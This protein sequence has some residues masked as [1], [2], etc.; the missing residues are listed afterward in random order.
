M[1]HLVNGGGQ[2][3]DHVIHV[4]S[5]LIYRKGF[6]TCPSESNTLKSITSNIRP[7]ACLTS[8]A[9][10]WN[11]APRSWH[12]THQPR[13]YTL[14]YHSRSWTLHS[15]MGNL[16]I[17]VG[18]EKGCLELMALIGYGQREISCSRKPSRNGP[19]Q[20]GRK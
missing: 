18:K 12:V 7:H 3:S 20:F 11:C 16:H 10:I 5:R 9:H 14:G 2:R 13:A 17:Q 1:G 15:Y 8:Q 6:K 4:C 19:K